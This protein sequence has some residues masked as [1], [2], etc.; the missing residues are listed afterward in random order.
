MNESPRSSLER[1]KQCSLSGGV[2][3][4]SLLLLRSWETDVGG[5]PGGIND[6]SVSEVGILF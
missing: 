6:T 4:D 1:R 3:S 5:A 2:Y